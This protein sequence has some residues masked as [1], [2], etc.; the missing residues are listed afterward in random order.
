VAVTGTVDNPRVQFSSDDPGLSQ[1]DVLSLVTL[2]RTTR[3]QSRDSGVGVGDILSL[4]PS[5]YTGD[6]SQQV[7]TIF[8]VDRFAVEPAYV[9]NTGTVEPRV[10]VGKDLTDRIRALASSS[11]GVEAHNTVQ[12]EY[13]ITSRISLV[14][15][16]ES[17]SSSQAGAFGGDIK[18]RYE[19]RKLPFSLLSSDLGLPQ[20][21]DA[22]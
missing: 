15:T 2:G 19:F 8:R 1:N 16:W 20:R 14:S 17:A 7:R 6:V 4:L 5:E 13:R 21:T 22:H 18:F 10:T 9:R 11:F 3:E 12:L